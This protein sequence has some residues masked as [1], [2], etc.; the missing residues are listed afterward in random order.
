MIVIKA[1]KRSDE[2]KGIKISVERYDPDSDRTPCLQDFVV[3]ADE[4]STVLDALLF[5]YDEMDST[6][7]FQFGCRFKNCG[8]CAMEINGRPRLACTTK[9]KPEMSIR[10]LS[11]LPRIRDLIIDRESINS[12]LSMFSPFLIRQHPPESEP[13]IFVQPEN[14]KIL[15]NCRECLSCLSS[16]PHYDYRQSHFGGPYSF[17]KLAR[18]YYDPRD[19]I[20]RKAQIRALGIE[21]CR[22]CRKCRCVVGIPIY[23]LAVSPFLSDLAGFEAGGCDHAETL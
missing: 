5:V 9:L 16:C 22:E 15:E 13:E 23:E 19:S 14:A 6:L 1:G 18:F 10:P 7:G 8:L 17:V 2:M 21:Q 4:G 20:D 3:P 11:R 12:N